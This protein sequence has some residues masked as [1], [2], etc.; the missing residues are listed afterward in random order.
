MSTPPRKRRFT[1]DVEPPVMRFQG[2][3]LKT[4]KIT[5]ALP[6]MHRASIPTWGQI[7]KLSQQ[8]EKLLEQENTSVTPN[9]LALAM[10]ALVLV[11]VSIPRAIAQPNNSTYTY[12]AYTPNPPLIRVVNWGENSIPVYVNDSSWV[13][14]PED[15]RLP[16]FEKEEGTPYETTDFGFD[17]WPI[18]IGRGRG[19]LN[20]TTQAWLTTY[21]LDRNHSK[22][23]LHM[24]WGYSFHY[25]IAPQN[26]LTAPNHPVCA[27]QRLWVD[28]IDQIQ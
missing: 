15:V 1:W 21:M 12:W 14:G 2:L 13:L 9:N 20:F 17:P 8:A 3:S 11:A 10:F 18:C 28:N 26:N 19:C 25:S 7:K 27:S 23:Q 5:F 16:I 24:L 22:T 6:Q 4:T